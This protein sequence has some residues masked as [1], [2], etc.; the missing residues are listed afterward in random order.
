MRT[1][2]TAC[3]ICEKPL[4][5]RPYE[6]ARVR[7]A[8]CMAHRAK[9]QIVVGITE[10]QQAGLARGRQKGTNNRNGRK[11]SDTTRAKRSATLKAYWA[12]NPEKAMARGAKTR[13]ELNVRWKGGSSKLNTSVR[14]L[15]ENRRWLDAIKARDGACVR[16]GANDDLESHHIVELAELIER[17][18]I[19]TRDQA[20]DCAALWDLSNGETLCRACHYA[21]HGRR[22]TA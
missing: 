13:G 20:R 1:P 18:G 4:Y 15:T 9:A 7:Y 16:C 5:R 19:T 17:H 21:H 6:L 12:D 2:N 10:A 3:I 8:A 14:Q 11:D 22:M